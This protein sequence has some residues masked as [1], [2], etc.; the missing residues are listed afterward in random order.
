MMPV[1][2]LAATLPLTGLRL[3]HTLIEGRGLC[4]ECRRRRHRHG[5][6]H[7]GRYCK[8]HNDALHLLYLLSLSHPPNGIPLKR[9]QVGCEFA[10]AGRIVYALAGAKQASGPFPFEIHL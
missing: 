2:Y 5:H 4:R 1:F 10:G 7:N 3:T 9:C 6:N 8:H